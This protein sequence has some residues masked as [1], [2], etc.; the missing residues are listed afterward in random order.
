[1][2]TLEPPSLAEIRA[3]R[4]RIAGSAIR[5]PL[6]R[7]EVDGPARIFLKLENLQPIGSFKLRGAG[8]AIAM[9]SKEELA[10]GVYSASAGNMAQGLAWHAR[11][12]GIS[13]TVVVPDSAPS[14][15]IAAIKRLG[16][17]IVPLPFA[18]WWRVIE[19]HHHPGIDATFIHPVSDPAVIAG[20][21]TIGLEIFEDLP[22]VDT[23]LVGYGGGALSS[24]IATALHAVKPGTKVYACEVTTAAPFAASLSAGRPVSVDYVPSFIDGIG[25]RTMLAE[26][27]PLA[28]RVL[29]GSLLVSPDEAAAALRLMVERNHVVAEGAGAVPVAAA[30]SGKAGAG[31]IACVVSGGNID[32]AKLAAILN[33]EA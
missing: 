17:S 27:W 15:K 11:R 30:L 5:T 18:D 3:A 24:G 29:A 22:D 4:D 13:C 7:F 1:M 19:T 6:V 20:N 10:R 21:A 26:M 14:T 28:S 12:L 2:R 32:A 25:G 8:N 33:G 16:A 9:R 31:T 23:V